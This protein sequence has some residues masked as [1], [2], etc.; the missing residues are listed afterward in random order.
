LGTFEVLNVDVRWFETISMQVC[1][2]MIHVLKTNEE[3]MSHAKFTNIM[4]ILFSVFFLFF[5]QFCDVAK[6][7]GHQ[8]EEGLE[9]SGLF[10]VPL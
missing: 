10:R 2:I 1:I 6:V 5:L 9:T 7:L 3:I 8:P 4:S